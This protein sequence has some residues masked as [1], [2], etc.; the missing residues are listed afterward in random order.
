MSLISNEFPKTNTGTVEDQFVKLAEADDSARGDNLKEISESLAKLSATSGKD[1]IVEAM[2][3]MLSFSDKMA[4]VKNSTEAKAAQ[5]V[6]SAQMV[7]TQFT[8]GEAVGETP[9]VVLQETVL[10]EPVV[11]TPYFEINKI[12]TFIKNRPPGQGDRGFIF[13]KKIDL[14]V[15]EV[16]HRKIGP[17]DNFE[18]R[19]QDPKNP[20]D[21]YDLVEAHSKYQ[22]RQITPLF[23]TNKDRTKTKAMGSYAEK[24]LFFEAMQRTLDHSRKQ[25]NKSMRVRWAK[26]LRLTE[27]MWLNMFPGEFLFHRNEVETV[28]TA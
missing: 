15:I 26:A 14:N 11:V 17:D 22:G 28:K 1:K 13:E 24:G 7:E 6:A 4:E 9:D 25:T 12:Y 10:Q 18:V 16:T 3:G 8:I 5:N 23:K 27:N 20:A 2:S 21:F 19:L